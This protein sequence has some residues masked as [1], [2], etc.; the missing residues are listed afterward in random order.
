M[1]GEYSGVVHIESGVVE[2]KAPSKIIGKVI[3][4]MNLHKDELL[5]EWDLSQQGKPLFKIDPLTRIMR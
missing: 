2:G 5:K 4:W 3:K 1:Y